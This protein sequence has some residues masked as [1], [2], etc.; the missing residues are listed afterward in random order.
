M[1]IITAHNYYQQRGGE[2]HVF[3]AET[4]MLRKAGHEV[5]EFT[6]RSEAVSGLQ[7]VS[8]AAGAVWGRS[9]AREISQLVRDTGAE[10]VHIHNWLPLMS[11]TVFSAARK[12][13]AAVV[14]TLH[15]YRYICPSGILFRDGATCRDCVGRRLALP[16]IRYACYHDSRAAT[17]VAVTALSFHGALGT[18]VDSIDAVISPSR[19]AADALS[20]VGF[21]AGL[22]YIKPNF[23]DRDPGTGT[24]AGDHVVF[25]G[26]LAPEKG[27]DTLLH[28]WE[29]I[30]E[31]IPL[32]VFGAGPLQEQVAAAARR[33]SR[34]DYRGFAPPA[35]F[36]ASLKGARFL[37]NPSRFYEVLPVSILEAFARGTPAVTSRFGAM[38]ELVEHDRTGVHVRVGDPDDLA[39]A[40][41]ELYADASRLAAMREEA[42]RE[43][44][45]HYDAEQ[46]Y[47]RLL[48]VY[49]RAA[50]HRS[51]TR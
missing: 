33:D 40:V 37:V 21:P 13:G 22:V 46:N 19:F 51:G 5:H 49:A 27:V 24:G 14:H 31:P 9:A 32:H 38:E 16:A 23:L 48:E 35:V 12:A 25:L 29:R 17:A 47:E 41:Q 39:R 45:E 4:A 11:P 26:R 7:A 10:I 34:I 8:T 15:N 28:A 20:T 6:R 50:E 2:D 43:F 42:R 36:D 1:R 30:T 3:E 44:L 18:I